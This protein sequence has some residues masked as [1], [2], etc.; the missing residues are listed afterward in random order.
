MF[1]NQQILFITQTT[2]KAQHLKHLAAELHIKSAA[3]VTFGD[4]K[5]IKDNP[6]TYKNTGILPERNFSFCRQLLDEKH[7][8]LQ[9]INNT[10]KN[11]AACL[12]AF[13]DGMFGQL[14]AF[15]VAQALPDINF[16]RLPTT[17]M[18]TPNNLQW[19]L[20]HLTCINKQLVDTALAVQT[21]DKLFLYSI[22]PLLKLF[23]GIKKLSRY[24][25]VLLCAHEAFRQ[26]RGL[27]AIP[28]TP[29]VAYLKQLGFSS[30]TVHACQAIVALKKSE[31]FVFDHGLD[32]SAVGKQL[33][34]F[35]K[36]Y[37]SKYAQLGTW[38]QAESDLK[39]IYCASLP[40]AQWLSRE[41]EYLRHGCEDAQK[42]L[43]RDA[44]VTDRTCPICGAQLLPRRN[45]FG[46][47]FF[48]C[49]KYPL[50]RGT[51][52]AH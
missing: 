16:Q 44:F 39:Y 29:L 13:E 36:T 50:C 1:E 45:R 15:D 4:L 42:A 18:A 22:S 6:N 27:Q 40:I 2:K 33:F 30:S 34:K 17:Y 21:F 31:F 14:R 12:L 8:I 23:I 26:N 28:E 11:Y 5:S 37:F 49:C 24:Q 46:Q 35:I 9:R 47:L 41:F 32:S 52:S 20:Q 25:L 38:L 3:I 19:A 7:A 48:G 51:R 43:M 10:A